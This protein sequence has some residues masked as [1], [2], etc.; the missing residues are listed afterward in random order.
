MSGFQDELRHKMGYS[1]QSCKSCKHF[2]GVDHSGESPDRTN[3]CG[4]YSELVL[5]NVLP[6]GRCDQYEGRLPHVPQ[7]RGDDTR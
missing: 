6:E 5:L 3:T 7:E 2:H 1:A 4:Q